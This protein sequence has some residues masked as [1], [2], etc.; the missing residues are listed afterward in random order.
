MNA[1]LF[2]SYLPW[3]R[4]PKEVILQRGLEE[5]YDEEQI[6]E[7]SPFKRPQPLPLDGAPGEILELFQNY[8]LSRINMLWTI[9]L[10]EPKKVLEGWQFATM[11]EARLVLVPSGR[12]EAYNDH[13]IKAIHGDSEYLGALA[14][15][16][17]AYL[18]AMICGAMIGKH[19]APG[20]ADD[21]GV[22]EKLEPVVQLC[23]VLA[24]G[25]E[26]EDFWAGVLGL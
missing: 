14:E 13:P 15:S 9:F 16:M 8:D 6:V 26:Y 11:S 12:I 22:K 17:D 21:P 20:F 1:K 25:P 5:D 2:F 24:G 10:P 19:F 4:L 18:D 7:T 3:L 23:T